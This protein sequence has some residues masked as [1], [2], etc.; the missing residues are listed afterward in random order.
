MMLDGK[1]S[2]KKI[3]ITGASSGIGRTVAFFLANLGATV[4]LIARNKNRLN[5]TFNSLSGSGHYKSIVDISN[6][7]N[8]TPL[9]DDI[10]NHCGQL[11]G[12]VHCAG[13]QHTMPLQM[14]S[15]QTF[16]NLFN[17]NTKSAL[18]LAKAFRRKGKYNT[19]GSS[20]IF[21]SSA[22]ALSGE[23]GISEYSASKL[24]LQGIARSLANELAK[25]KI[26][27]NC[28]APGVVKTEMSANFIDTLTPEQFK[29]ITDK[30][31]LG[32][33]H[34]EDVAAYSAFLLSDYAKWITGTSL[35]VDGGYTLG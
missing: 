10:F 13:I 5:E 17:I 21:L 28:I 24:A 34:P 3:L 31:P 1:L 30:H 8:I 33:G 14:T 29:T 32:L 11:D 22:A 2:N 26:R 25:Q 6:I 27:V 16:D 7:D 12:L 35:S 15:E 9:M 20:I 23:A 19:N 4:V 18:F